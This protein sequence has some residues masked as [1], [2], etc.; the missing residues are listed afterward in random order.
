MNRSKGNIELIMI[1]II[2]ALGFL[3][4]GGFSY[5]K[6]KNTNNARYASS[7]TCCDTGDG[8]ACA[9]TDP[10][11]TW[12]GTNVQPEEYALLKSGIALSEGNGHLDEA[13]APDNMTSSGERIY[14]NT[15]NVTFPNG[16]PTVYSPGSN[17]DCQTPGQDFIFKKLA[18]TVCQG[19]P[20]DEIIYVC[21]SNCGAKSG[22]S[23]FDAYFRVSDGEIPDAIKNCEKPTEAD[24]SNGGGGGQTIIVD[25]PDKGRNNLQLKT[26]K[27]I[28]NETPA[29]WLSPYC[30][31]AIYLYP[32]AETN[33]NVKV[34]PLGKMTLTIPKYPSTGWDVL[35]KPDGQ[36][37]SNGTNYDYLYYEAEIPDENIQ[38]PKDG[39]VVEKKN[40]ETLLGNILPSLGLNKKETDQ[41][42]DYWVK[43]LP[44]SPYYFVGVVAQKN[45]DTIAPLSISPRPQTVIRITLY[46]EA[47]DKKLEIKNPLI[48][49]V[50]RQG[51][52]VVE[53]GG[54]FKRDKDHNFSCFM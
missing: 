49:P 22:A 11:I 46:F 13:P 45:I 2:L 21:K 36:I 19:I 8:D 10:R 54:I 40:V 24:I 41:F 14:L 7:Y 12:K 32:E 16:Y 34:N 9:L 1:V 48:L 26:F 38:K 42:K 15:T 31:P 47:L 18:G 3:L 30:K 43:V 35:A 28:E 53:W 23:K 44:E 29:Q 5:Q 52:T 4:A 50:K 6:K 20:N 39:F 17:N 33:I 27:I 51:F 25:P 37:I